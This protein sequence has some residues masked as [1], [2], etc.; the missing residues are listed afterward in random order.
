MTKHTVSSDSTGL[1]E[2]GCLHRTPDLI[3]KWKG[4]T[5]ALAPQFFSSLLTLHVLCRILAIFICVVVKVKCHSEKTAEPI[6]VFERTAQWKSKLFNIVRVES[7]TRK[8]VYQKY[9]GTPYFLTTNSC[10]VEVIFSGDWHFIMSVY[11]NLSVLKEQ[12]LTMFSMTISYHSVANSVLII[13]VDAVGWG[14]LL[15]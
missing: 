12:F 13:I 11:A 6:T 15:K 1:R 2:Q 7:N 10:I 5:V 4:I 3:W 8:V 9:L 14:R